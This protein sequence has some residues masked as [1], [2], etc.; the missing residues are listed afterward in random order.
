MAHPI[1]YDCE[2]CGAHCRRPRNSKQSRV[3]LECG[4][5]RAANYNRDLAARSGPGYAHWAARTAQTAAI[6]LR[7]TD[8]VRQPVA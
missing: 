2:D 4:V 7:G 3:C 6:A 1:E 8:T 5:R